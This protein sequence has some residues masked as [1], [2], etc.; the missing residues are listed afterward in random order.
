MRLP[1]GAALFAVACGSPTP[2]PPS[3][4]IQ[5][6]PAAICV[7][8]A[9]RTPVTFDGSR[10]VERLAVVPVAGEPV[11]FSWTLS[12]AS[13][14]LVSGSLQSPSLVVTSAGD[15]PLHASLLV[16]APSGASARAIATL[17]LTVDGAAD[18]GCAP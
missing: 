2:V 4:V 14:R 1:A 13:W 8:D 7:D 3:A 5:I 11:R 9:H 10:S 6:T 18:A 15:R 16:T 12:G 17:G